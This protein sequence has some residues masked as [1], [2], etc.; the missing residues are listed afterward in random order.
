MRLS[1][2]LTLLKDPV[3]PRILRRLPDEKSHAAMV[4]TVL[5]G[6][7]KKL[8]GPSYHLHLADF[9]RAELTTDQALQEWLEGRS[10]GIPITGKSLDVARKRADL[11]LREGKWVALWSYGA[12]P[13]SGGP[14]GCPQVLFGQGCIEPE[15][16]RATFFNSRKPKIVSPQAGWLEVLRALL[17]FISAHHL[18]FA[19]SL[20]TS[21]YDLVT[22]GA[23][24]LGSRL[25]LM[26]PTPLENLGESKYSRMLDAASFPGLVLT[27]VTD[28][29]N[30]PKAM[31]L[32]CRDRLLAFISDLHC[33]LELRP[34]G[35]LL[36]IIKKHQSEQSR[37]QWIYR[38]E[39]C[40]AGNV[41]NLEILQGFPQ[42]ATSFSRT[43]LGIPPTSCGKGKGL[44][45]SLRVVDES[46]IE[47]QDYLYHYT[48]SCP[49]PWPNQSYRDHLLSLLHNE[50]LAEHTALDTLTRML[51]EGCIRASSKIVRGDQAV[52]SWT[53]RPPPDLKAIRRWNP[54]LI[55]WTFEPYG[56]A[57]KKKV[58]R[59]L[60]TK[61]AIYA[62]SA[63]YEQLTREERFRF[64]LHDPPH[65]SWKNEREWRLP[66]D[67]ELTCLTPDEAFAFVSMASDLHRLA[68]QIACAL[69]IVVL[70]PRD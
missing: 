12:F 57:V 45:H 23:E 28:A 24:Q 62:P 7:N 14:P 26:L 50:P 2:S 43:D 19:S 25:L 44:Q 34:G 38:P 29:V 42:S 47:W 59:G 5:L 30:C 3:L 61:P 36:E 17:P 20:G 10:A 22:V 1:Q 8:D 56:I 32:V 70:Q 31:R 13:P 64:Q 4:L 58:L 18:G 51:V 53:S 35:N 66:H 16:F 46:E 41:G 9:L 33:I 27:C 65:C 52:V 63:V 37:L 54:A 55:R 11:W 49:G 67:F 60:G 6:R 39:S 68:E 15:L 48:R 21:T 40:N 69:P